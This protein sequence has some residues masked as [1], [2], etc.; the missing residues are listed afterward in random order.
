MLSCDI[1]Y[2]WVPRVEL[3]SCHSSGTWNLEVACRSLKNTCDAD[4]AMHFLPLRDVT[5]VNKAGKAVWQKQQTYVNV[6]SVLTKPLLCSCLSFNIYLHHVLFSLS[7]KITNNY[8][9]Q[10]MHSTLIQNT[11]PPDT[12]HTNMHHMD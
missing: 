2:L 7:F 8:K 4:L 3:A 1:H 10:Q 6:I 11:T 12:K 9:N 5:Q